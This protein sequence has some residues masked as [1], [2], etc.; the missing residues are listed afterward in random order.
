MVGDVP[1]DSA[2]F[3]DAYRGRVSQQKN[4]LLSRIEVVRVLLQKNT[5]LSWIEMVLK[6]FL[7]LFYLKSRSIPNGVLQQKNTL[8]SRI[9]VVLKTF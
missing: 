8:L 3:E 7:I 5:L 6:A 1:V 9:E 4:T 2:F